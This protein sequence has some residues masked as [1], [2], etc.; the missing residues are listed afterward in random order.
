MKVPAKLRAFLRAKGCPDDLL[1]AQVK[2]VLTDMKKGVRT[3]YI[4]G[5]GEV[6]RA[7]LTPAEIEEY[8]AGGEETP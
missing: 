2:M 6:V 5:V 4:E 7:A 1:D 3:H 8:L